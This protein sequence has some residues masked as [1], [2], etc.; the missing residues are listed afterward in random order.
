MNYVTNK[1]INIELSQD[2]AV[3]LKLE[4]MKI[5]EKYGL[6]GFAIDY[7][8]ATTLLNSLIGEYPDY[9]K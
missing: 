5:Q 2:E 4:L 7:P 9:D 8:L 3:S 1:T 6:A